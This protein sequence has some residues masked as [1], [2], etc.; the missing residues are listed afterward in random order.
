MI[1]HP[2][3]TL[4][5]GAVILRYKQPF[6][7][8]LKTNDPASCNLTLEEI[9]NDDGEVFLIQDELSEP[10]DN[11]ETVV[12]WVEKRWRMFFEH[13]LG[14]WLDDEALWPRKLSLKMFRDWFCIE[15]LS[16]VWDM[17]QE[18]LSVEDWDDFNDEIEI[19]GTLH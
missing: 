10:A 7:D 6:V 19:I 17:G 13:M 3:F 18:P 4:N 15:Y 14:D 5:R 1:D 9:N 8:W 11:R 12:R 2:R 16:M